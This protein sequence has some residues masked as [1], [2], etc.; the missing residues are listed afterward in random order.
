MWGA[1]ILGHRVQRIKHFLEKFV[2]PK[3]FLL[4][5]CFPN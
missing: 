4:A 3:S 2:N 1:E 5:G